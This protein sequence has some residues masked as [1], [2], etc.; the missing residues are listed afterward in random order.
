[1]T[2]KMCLRYVKRTCDDLFKRPLHVFYHSR[3]FN[4]HKKKNS[5]LNDGASAHLTENSTVTQHFCTLWRL[6][7]IRR[8]LVTGN[9]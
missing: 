5:N 4:A 3:Q 6:L 1:M 2:F 7:A 9:L 8:N